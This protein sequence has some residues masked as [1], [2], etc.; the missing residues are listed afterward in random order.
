MYSHAESETGK[1]LVPSNSV[2]DDAFKFWNKYRPESVAQDMRHHQYLIGQPHTNSSGKTCKIV[3]LGAKSATVQ[4][5]DGKT[6]THPRK[7]VEHII[8][9]HKI[10]TESTETLSEYDIYFG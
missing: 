5:E 9:A 4:Y 2:S 3:S 7:D 1:Q 10:M 6:S 8:D